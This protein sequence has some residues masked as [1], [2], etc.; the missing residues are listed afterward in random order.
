MSVSPA[1]PSLR[2]IC[3]QLCHDNPGI[4]RLDLAGWCIGDDG[5]AALGTSFQHI[6]STLYL[7]LSYNLISA[8]GASSMMHGILHFHTLDLCHNCIGDDG[9][10]AIA[11]ALSSTSWEGS[12]SWKVNNLFL[13]NN[14]ISCKGA[15]SISQAL[16]KNTTVENLDLGTN[17]IGSDGAIA[18][19][20]LLQNNQTLRCL[21]LWSNNFKASDVERISNGL[22][23]NVALEVINLGNNNV[24][25]HGAEAISKM[26]R[27]NCSLSSIHIAKAAI[28]WKGA[29]KLAES[30][31]YNSV[32]KVLDVLHNPI[33]LKG[34]S[35]FCYS[36]RNFNR[37]IQKL[38]FDCL[39]EG[40]RE[41]FTLSGVSKEILIYLKLNN[42]GRA[43]MSD[44]KLPWASWP[45]ILQK[46]NIEADLLYL[47]LQEKP[48]LF[49]RD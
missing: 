38:R 49:L 48:D 14:H 16:E 35:A 6:S 30:L 37:N 45:I 31:A 4:V 44:V 42:S 11:N 13:R 46:I 43:K 3:Q 23:Q 18:I 41:S 25:D 7:N 10:V 39:C 17:D 8:K 12:I 1:P 9:A 47:T 29:I 15:I 22:H 36:L 28:E 21:S 32:L 33:G 20:R 2:S 34:A 5:A 27:V 40:K 26:L 24:C 19:E